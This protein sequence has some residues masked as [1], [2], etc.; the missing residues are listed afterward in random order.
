MFIKAAKNCLSSGFQALT[1]GHKRL[2]DFQ[3]RLLFSQF[4]VQFCKFSCAARIVIADF[5]EIFLG[6]CQLSFIVTEGLI[7]R[8]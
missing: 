3:T 4:T 6:D 7:F 1:L 2:E 5:L 8:T